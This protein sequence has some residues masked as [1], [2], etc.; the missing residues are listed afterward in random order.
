MDR[1]SKDPV[2]GPVVVVL[3]GFM[4][5]GK[6]TVG[7]ALARRLGWEFVDLDDRIVAR[8]ERSIAE[9]FRDHG[10]PFF[11]R[12]ES[13]ALAELLAES[14]S[15]RVLALG[16]GAF[17]QKQNRELLRGT[18]VV[19]LDA[20]AEELFAR[21]SHSDIARP[22]RQDWN[23][24]RQLYESRRGAYMESATRVETHNKTVEQV[25]TEVAARLGLDGRHHASH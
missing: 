23:Q 20:P 1:P 19:F 7:G 15:A 2:P 4:G 13:E 14:R 18:P 17:V 24:F 12:L 9:I 16:G 5:A 21:C 3:I 11:R 25:A 8:A 22:L 6:T 10:E